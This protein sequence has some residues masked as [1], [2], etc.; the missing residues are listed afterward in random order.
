VWRWWDGFAWGEETIPMMEDVAR[1]AGRWIDGVRAE[2]GGAIELRDR[3]AI[4]GRVSWGGRYPYLDTE[5]NKFAMLEA[6]DGRWKAKDIRGAGHPRHGGRINRS[7]AVTDLSER[8]LDAFVISRDVWPVEGAD[9]KLPRDRVLRWTEH[10]QTDVDGEGFFEGRGEAGDGGRWTLDVPP[11]ATNL[12]ASPATV[13][14]AELAGGRMAQSF[15]P[16]MH[17]DPDRSLLALLAVYLVFHWW[18]SQSKSDRRGP[19]AIGY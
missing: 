17:A 3:G 10:D 18:D 11:P 13:L 2:G 6:V 12:T 4:V 9:F 8:G 7:V 5:H 14:W 19:L 16:G 15:A 1:A